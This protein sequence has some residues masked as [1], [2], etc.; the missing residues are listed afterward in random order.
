MMDNKVY[1]EP[2]EVA[3]EDGVVVVDGPD[4]V[5]VLMTLD[6]AAET[7]ERLLAGAVEA[8]GQRVKKLLRDDP[9]R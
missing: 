1:E 2:S 9:H 6:A 3:A 7:S 5:A 8:Q 4:A